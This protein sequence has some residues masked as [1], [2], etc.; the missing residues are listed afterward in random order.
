MICYV[1]KPKGSRVWRGR[2][3]LSVHDELADVPLRTSEK[4][5]AQQRLRDLVRENEHEAAGII[6]KKPIREAAQ[7]PLS[8][9]L[10][11]FVADLQKIGR[12]DSHVRNIEWRVGVLIRECRWNTVID[13]TAESFQRWRQRQ[14]LAAK[15]LNDYLS[16]IGSLLNWLEKSG[17]LLGNP[18]KAVEKVRTEGREGRR[19]RA[20]TE[21]ELKQLI[22]AA[23]ERKAVYLMAVHTGL[24]R[25]ELM[26]LI[27]GDIKLDAVVPFVEVRA[28]TTKNKKPARIRLHDEVVAAL[29]ESKPTGVKDEDT[30]FKRFP[31]IERFRRDLKKAG[32]NYADAQGRVADFHALRYTFCTRLANSGV[33]S[34]V[35]MALMRHSDRRLTDKIYTDE[36]LLGT[37]SAIESLPSVVNV[38]SQLASQK[39]GSD[40]QPGALSGTVGGGLHSQEMHQINGETRDF[41]VVDAGNG[42]GGTGGS[43]GAR[44]RNL[45]RDRA[46]L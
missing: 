45:C 23:G 27:W 12:T 41:A 40:G 2:Y 7:R 37:W 33:P 8:Q 20:F 30:V 18:L 4:Q 22:A 29:R 1:Y 32:I 43:D 36:N 19:R 38:A 21:L 13:V 24:R 31:R 17:R 26:N 10:D 46:A 5:V 11:D 14:N 28:S 25:S 15:T 34:R 42:E 3:R 39:P 44:T 16:A 35:A 6:A 9:H